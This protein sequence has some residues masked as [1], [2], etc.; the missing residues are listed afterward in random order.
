MAIA[1]ISR[2]ALHKMISRISVALTVSLLFPVGGFAGV[3]SQDEALQ[4]AYNDNQNS[5]HVSR[6]I[7]LAETP[8]VYT[9]KDRNGEPTIYLFRTGGECNGFVVVSAEEKAYSLLGYSG[10]TDTADLS[11]FSQFEN[12]LANLELFA[13][14][15][16]QI[17]WVKYHD[18][19]GGTELSAF[20]EEYSSVSPLIHTAWSQ[21]EPYNLMCPSINGAHC[22][23]GCNPVAFCQVMKY[24]NWPPKGEGRHSYRDNSGQTLSF[25]YSE[26]TFP[27]HDMLNSYSTGA[28]ES[29]KEDVARVLYGMGVAMDTRYGLEGSAANAVEGAAALSKYFRYENNIRII[30]RQYYSL[31]QWISLLYDQLKNKEPIIYSVPNHTFICDGYHQGFLHFNWGWGGKLNGYFKPSAIKYD[32]IP[33]GENYRH[34]ILAGIRPDNGSVNI[35]TEPYLEADSLSINTKSILLGNNVSARGNFRNSTINSLKFGFGLRATDSGNRIHYLESD[36]D[37]EL[38]PNHLYKEISVRVPHDMPVGI[39]SLSPVVKCNDQ[40]YDIALSPYRDSNSLMVI[41]DSRANFFTSMEEASVYYNSLSK[42][43]LVSR[44]SNEPYMTCTD[45]NPS[46]ITVASGDQFEI[47]GRFYNSGSENI[48]VRLGVMLVNKKG[49]VEYFSPY[50][51]TE[52]EPSY[53]FSSLKFNLPSS[54]K[55]GTYRIHPAFQEQ[56]SEKWFKIPVEDNSDSDYRIVITKSEGT[57]RKDK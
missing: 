42:E 32:Y 7:K 29:L 36:Y 6:L 46:E 2:I 18:M 39:Y 48:S 15:S 4:R 28:S 5:S 20:G 43:Q 52:L 47:T 23:T 3:L 38:H 14:Y 13:E 44:K 53:F 27:W 34:K 24:Y 22:V 56:K 55:D 17:D 1:E 25:D 11:M 30:N 33:T 49:E 54:L 37:T 16:E 12:F 8:A 9:W 19:N 51:F 26:E 50:G 35:K 40:W 57:L 31:S 10:E 41:G 21:R 45:F